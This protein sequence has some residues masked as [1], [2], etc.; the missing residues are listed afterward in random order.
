[1]KRVVTEE[2]KRI[3]AEKREQFKALA[4]R[5]ASM[6][7]EER[8]ELCE[9]MGTVVNPDGKA[10]SFKNSALCYMQRGPCTMVGGFL[11]WK[12]LG[13]SVRKGETGMKIFI[14]VTFKDRGKA[15]IEETDS[16][17]KKPGFMIGTVFDVSQTE[18]TG[19]VLALASTD[20]ADD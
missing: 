16:T 18:E 2:Q 4:A 1:M 20:S 9:K 12:K 3:A 17:G 19:A 8:A 14:P 15:E 13:R 7:D 6:S 10:L 11:Q 5:L